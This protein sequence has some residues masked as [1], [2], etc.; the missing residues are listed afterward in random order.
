MFRTKRTFQVDPQRN[1]FFLEMNTR[2][3]VEHPVTELI[4]G[5]D[6]VEQMIRIGAGEKLSV[7]Q[8]RYRA[9]PRRATPPACNTG[10]PIARHPLALNAVFVWHFWRRTTFLLLEH[11]AGQWRRASTRR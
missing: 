7:T 2:L 5:V 11:T 1:F 9:A 4:T 8:V 6:L 10:W 3:Q